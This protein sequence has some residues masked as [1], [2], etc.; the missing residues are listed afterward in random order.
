MASWQRNR[1]PAVAQSKTALGVIFMHVLYPDAVIYFGCECESLTSVLPTRAAIRQRV[2]NY[3]CAHVPRAKTRICTLN[4]FRCRRGF[5]SWIGFSL[6]SIV[7]GYF[8]INP[9]TRFLIT[10]LMGDPLNCIIILNE[11]Q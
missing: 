6:R 10:I 2:L 1:H 3:L 5:L 8:S 9:G 11:S 4:A 7:S